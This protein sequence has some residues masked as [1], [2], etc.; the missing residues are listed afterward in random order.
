MLHYS[1]IKT[2]LV[3]LPMTLAIVV[4]STI[5]SR[6]TMRFG[7]KRL[8]VIG[9]TALAIGLAWLSDIGVRPDYVG[10]LLFPGVLASFAMPFAFI[11][12]T[13]CA[14]TGVKPQ[15]AGLASALVN[16]ARLF[17]GALGL[18][19]LATIATSHSNAELR[20]P[21]AAIHTAGAALVSGFQLAFL[22]AG[23][24]AAVGMVVALFGM[25]SARLSEATA[26]QA[27]VAAEM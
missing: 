20:H 2:G 17:G 16:N 18:A 23:G 9:M 3:F 8:L 21:T 6:I 1:P 25:P 12:G 13:I 26:P 24:I 5:A 15:E 22:V 14:T 7:A 4:G 10:E 27:A 11:P 19:I